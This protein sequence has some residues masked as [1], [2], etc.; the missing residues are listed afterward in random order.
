MKKLLSILIAV[1]A[2]EIN[3]AQ[4]HSQADAD[5]I[6]GAWQT[7]SG[8]GRILITKYGDNKFGGKI[9]WLREPLDAKGKPKTDVKN[10]DESKRKRPKMGLNNLLGF[11]YEGNNRFENGTIYDPENGKTYKCIIT[12]INK[13]TLTI[14]GYSGITLIS[15]TDT[16][17][18]V[19]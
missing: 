1:L 8:K 16:W 9:I 17:R 19:K 14:K 6:L 3:F 13:N 12:L 18:R 5:K 15:R 4:T 11:T 10:P 7:G 2:I